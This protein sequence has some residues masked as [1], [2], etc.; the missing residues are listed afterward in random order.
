VGRSEPPLWF[1]FAGMGTQWAGMA[2]EIMSIDVIRTSIDESAAILKPSGFDLI[3]LLVNENY[4]GMKRYL[5]LALM[6]VGVRKD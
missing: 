2:K 6:A 1:I 3:D 5:G 4:E